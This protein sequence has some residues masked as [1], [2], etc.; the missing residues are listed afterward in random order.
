MSRHCGG[1]QCAG[2][3][4]WAGTVSPQPSTHRTADLIDQIESHLGGRSHFEAPGS[5]PRCHRWARPLLR[6]IGRDIMSLFALSCGGRERVLGWTLPASEGALPISR[7]KRWS[8][9]H[10]LRP[11]T[12]WMHVVSK[13]SGRVIIGRMRVIIG[14]MVVSRR[15]S[16]GS[17]MPVGR[18]HGSLVYLLYRLRG[19][20]KRTC[21]PGCVA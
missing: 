17:S 5:D 8:P 18:R 12:R 6:L 13:A 14:R 1:V 4:M 10:P 19:S 11:A 21:T 2:C 15:A 16:L 7:R 3:R 9:C 20:M